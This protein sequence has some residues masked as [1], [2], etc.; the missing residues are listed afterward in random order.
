[1]LAALLKTHPTADELQIVLSSSG[2]EDF[3]HFEGIPHLVGGKVISDAEE[4]TELIKSVVFTEFE[5][6]E[7]ILTD[8]RVANIAQYNLSLIHI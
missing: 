8:A 7:K 1:M 2:L 4:A 5:R 6:R 3:I